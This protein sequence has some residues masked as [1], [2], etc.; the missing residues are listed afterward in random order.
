M[1]NTFKDLKCVGSHLTMFNRMQ[2]RKALEK[3]C[4]LC[5]KRF[6]EHRDDSCPNS[7]TS[8]LDL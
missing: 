3:T 4:H 2:I 7:K 1:Y 8:Y 6:S 5:K